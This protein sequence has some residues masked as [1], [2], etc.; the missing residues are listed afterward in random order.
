MATDLETVQ[1]VVLG[2]GSLPRAVRASM[3]PPVTIPTFEIDGR[4]L[5][6]GGI[7]DNVPVDVARAMGASV[8][9][10]VDVTSPPLRRD[11]WGDIVGAGRQLIDALMREHAKQWAERAD[12]V[13]TPAL[14]GRGAE[15]FSDPA[16]A[17]RGRARGGPR[18]VR[19]LR[20]LGA[21]GPAPRPPPAPPPALPWCPS[22]R[23]AARAGSPSAR[24]ARS[25][26]AG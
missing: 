18:G 9:V 21:A 8:V 12:L 24:S 7:V 23:C 3:S 20:A 15:D 13:I 10:A 1:P 6:D 17:D 5:V 14:Q 16:R 26:A 22:W 4:V 19:A 25:S 11:Q 2:R